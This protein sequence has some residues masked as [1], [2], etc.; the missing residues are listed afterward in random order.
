MVPMNCFECTCSVKTVK[1]KGA[2]FFNRICVK[3]YSLL[4][5]IVAKPYDQLTTVMGNFNSPG[6]TCMTDSSK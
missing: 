6:W 4:Y 1:I 2:C 3:D 5:K